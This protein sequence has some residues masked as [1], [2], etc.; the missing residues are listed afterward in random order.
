[1][2][3]KAPPCFC[4]TVQTWPQDAPAVLPVCGRPTWRKPLSTPFCS[5]EVGSAI[6]LMSVLQKL[7]KNEARQSQSAATVGLG[8]PARERADEGR[9]GGTSDRESLRQRAN[10]EMPVLFPAVVGRLGR[11][12]ASLTS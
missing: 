12:E 7:F 11:P 10:K 1:M 6:W 2:V 3:P 4:G 9:S 8:S 5:V